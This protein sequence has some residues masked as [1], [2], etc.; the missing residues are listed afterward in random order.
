MSIKGHSIVVSGVPVE[1][2]RK[3][4]KNLYLGVYPPNGRVRVAAPLRLNDD[5]LR[6]AV[7]TR[8]GWIRKQQ[9]GF[10]QQDRQSQRE[11]VTGETH[12]VQGRRYRL[13]VIESD[14]SPGIEF[15]PMQG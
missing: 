14:G 7:V 2:V 13:N 15:D 3:D 9:A 5:A 12:Y 6:L 10:E 11:M 8:L 4:I 1:I